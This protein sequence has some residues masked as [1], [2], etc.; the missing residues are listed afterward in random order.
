MKKLFFFILAAFFS[1]LV[2][3]NDLTFLKNPDEKKLSGEIYFTENK[4]QVSGDDGVLHPEVKYTVDLGNICLFIMNHGISYQFTKIHYPEGYP[5]LSRKKELRN[6]ET[7]KE[8]EKQISVETYRMNMMLEGANVSANISTE[9]QTP[10]YFNYHNMNVY[11]V[12]SYGKIT[13]HDIYPGIDWVLYTKNGELK[14]DFILK[15][16]ADPSLIKL[17]FTDH[18]GLSL[19]PDGSFSLK[20]R[21]GSIGEK[22]PK[23]FQDGKEIK[24]RFVLNKNSIS[25]QLASYHKSQA[26]TIDPSLVWASYY[27]DASYNGGSGIATDASGNVYLCGRTSPS[28]GLAAS[29]YQNTYGGGNY[30]AFLVKFNSS[31]SRVWAT[32]FGGAGIDEASQCAVDPFGDVYIAGDT[33]SATG[34]ASGGHQNSLSGSGDAYLAKFNGSGQMIWSTYYGGTGYE[35]AQCCSVD[36]TGNVCMSGITGS[37]NG[38]AAGSGFQTIYGGMDDL[39]VVK[40]DKNGVRQWGTYFGGP[41]EEISGHSCILDASGNIYFTGYTQS[42]TGIASGGF[43]N[44]HGGAQYDAFLVKLDNNGSLQWSTYYGG[45]ADDFG[46]SCAVDN[47]GNVCLA[48][49]S[50]SASNIAFSGYQNTY[51]GGPSDAFLAKFNSNGT[52]LWSTYCGGARMD[53]ARYCAVDALNNIYV[54]GATNSY[55]GIGLNG[56]R[57]T[58]NGGNNYDA[59]VI[60]INNAGT[61][62]WGTYYGGS[63]SEYPA[64]CAIDDAQKLYISGETDSNTDIAFNG[65][66]NTNAGGNQD[67]FLA[68]ICTEDIP[69]TTAISGSTLVC[70]GSSATYSVTGSGSVYSWG[71]PADWTGSST[72]NNITLTPGSSGTISVATQSNGCTSPTQTI[73]V[74]YGVPAPSAITGN[75]QLCAGNSGVYSVATTTITS[76]TYSW[77]FPQSWTGSSTTNTVNVTPS[78]TGVMSVSIQNGACSS[79]IQTLSVTVSPC[80]GVLAYDAG[81][82]YNI[83]PNPTKGE[84]FVET[85]ENGTSLRIYDALGK[86][87]LEKEL[88]KGISPID[89]GPFAKGIYFMELRQ[90]G[91]AEFSM[92][93]RE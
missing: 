88:K 50:Q 53:D 80:T 52:R 36:A 12:R 45:P 86:C 2:F 78:A 77:T 5:E 46:I 82:A 87:V 26:L 70:T 30:D 25:F 58:F 90:N 64:T 74:T 20:N 38:I 43:Q 27:G 33:R 76:A 57:N 19:N 91:H 66:Q 55:D 65:F 72:S 67:A 16:G 42:L 37:S 71:F 89:L 63:G 75:I 59:F 22:A 11:N 34:I 48:G 83:Y 41:N 6:T 7:L 4:G 10:D 44:T 61:L 23:S 47:S 54:L 39:F 93:I 60:K 17:K 56:F 29:G 1:G 84:V 35:F 13:Y 79:S 81:H 18:E 9:N 40:F 49:V 68:K 51:G 14:Y 92:V 15:P 62:Q 3:P 85:K 21:M 24:T 32:Y 8:L 69:A 28:T 31:G 73:S